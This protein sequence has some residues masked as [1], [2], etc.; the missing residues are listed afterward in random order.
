LEAGSGILNQTIQ[1]DKGAD[2]TV[3]I[4]VLAGNRQLCYLLRV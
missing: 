4:A 3:G 2:L 1:D